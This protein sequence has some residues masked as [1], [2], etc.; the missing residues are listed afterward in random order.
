MKHALP[1][2]KISIAVLVLIAPM[3]LFAQ[4]DPLYA[5]YITNPFVLNPA[6]AGLSNN[7]ALGLSY[8]NQWTGL[9]GSPQTV[10]GNAHMALRHSKM[11]GGFMFIDDRTGNTSVTE[12]M[13]AYSYQI[14]VKSGTFLSFGMQAGFANYRT[15]NSKVTAFDAS[16]PLFSGS[17]TNTTPRIGFG[18]ILRN[19]RF[20][21]GISI[22]RML[23]STTTEEGFS[24]A[25]Y[26]QHIY[27][28][29]A[30]S[31]VATERIRIRPSALVKWVKGASPSVDLNCTAIL[32]EKYQAG[33]LTRNFNTYGLL[34]QAGIG[35]MFVFGYVFEIPTGKSADVSFSTHEITLG[36]RLRVLKFHEKNLF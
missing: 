7:L 15:D 5:Q 23:K 36:L 26:T 20:M 19:D 28:T 35:D 6:Y 25:Q 18:V 33:L 22:P 1:I 13:A 12:A 34:A 11:G 30:Y 8:R 31:F 2:I 21:A 10:N 24:Y 4:R 27:L 14:E 32:F 16:D 17:T 9:E 29:G 3:Q